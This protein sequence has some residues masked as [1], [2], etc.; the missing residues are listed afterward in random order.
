[1]NMSHSDSICSRMY[2]CY[3]TDNVRFLPKHPVDH[4]PA[5]CSTGISRVSDFKCVCDNECYSK[6]NIVKL[7]TAYS[8]SKPNQYLMYLV[9][10]EVE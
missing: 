7:F 1:M 4:R 8:K 3:Q 5:M 9:L 10:V 2:D 6:G